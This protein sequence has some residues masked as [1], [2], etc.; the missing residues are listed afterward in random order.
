MKLVVTGDRLSV[1]WKYKIRENKKEVDE[2]I[3]TSYSSSFPTELVKLWQGIDSVFLYE[4]EDDGG[5]VVSPVVVDGARKI[6]VSQSGR[7]SFMIA[8]P[9]RLLSLLVD[10]DFVVFSFDGVRVLLSLF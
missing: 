5:Y 9:K 3:Y 8:L 10:S 1:E 4:S 6:R 7:E 2:K